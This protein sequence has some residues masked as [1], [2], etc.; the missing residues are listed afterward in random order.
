LNTGR[1]TYRSGI[2]R[3]KK[4]HQGFTFYN[5]KEIVKS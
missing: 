1:G 4:I 5:K 2:H 3:P